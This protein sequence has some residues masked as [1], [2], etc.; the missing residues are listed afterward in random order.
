MVAEDLSNTCFCAVVDFCKHKFTH[1]KIKTDIRR[2]KTKKK[3]N[4]ILIEY[5]SKQTLKED[6]FGQNVE[7][8]KLGNLAV[9]FNHVSFSI[10]NPVS[11][12][13]GYSHL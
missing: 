4:Y 11:Y 8:P 9:I 7:T 10:K 6:L 13:L 3:L 5:I 2:K 1:F 12:T